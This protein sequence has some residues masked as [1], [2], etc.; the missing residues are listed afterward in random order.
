MSFLNISPLSP[1][2][3]KNHQIFSTQLEPKV[4]TN[5]IIDQGIL[6]NQE[7]PIIYTKKKNHL[8][9]KSNSPLEKSEKS[10]RSIT[11]PSRKG[12]SKVKSI[13]FV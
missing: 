5:F 3:N 11:S 6:R 2:R 4:D 8:L 9:E 12:N 13:K 1:K 7:S 10:R